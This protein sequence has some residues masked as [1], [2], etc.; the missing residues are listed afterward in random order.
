[1][2]GKAKSKPKP[3][4]KTEKVKADRKD[5]LL[6]NLPLGV[7]EDVLQDLEEEEEDLDIEPEDMETE[8][9][10]EEEDLDI[11]DNK[12]IQAIIREKPTQAG[13]VSDD[14]VRLYLREIGRVKLLDADSEFRLA[15]ILEAARLVKNVVQTKRPGRKA[16]SKEKGIYL[17]VIRIL[18][19]CKHIQVDASELNIPLPDQ[20]LML[21]EAQ[22]LKHT[23]Q[24]D[25]PSY[26]RS[27]LDKEIWSQQE[28][29]V[30]LVSTIYYIFLGYYVLPEEMGSWL[31][32][33]LEKKGSLPNRYTLSSKLPKPKILKK[34]IEII[35]ERARDAGQVIIRSNLRLV[36][37][38]AKRYMGRGINFLD[39][40][41]EGNLGLLRAVN[42][43]DPR[44]GFKF[45][46][47]A[48]WWIRQSINRS[49]AEQ[50]RTIRLPVHLFESITR[51]MRVQRDLV[52]ELGA[53]PATTN[54]PW[55]WVIW[56]MKMWQPSNIRFRKK[57]HWTRPYR[58]AGQMPLI[59]WSESCARLK[60]RSHWKDR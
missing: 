36:V 57:Y 37:S 18:A 10:E 55:L 27:Y 59:R 20:S 1:M 56:L 38:V 53:T 7:G 48:T 47:Y 16:S 22:M 12:L 31:L 41:Q 33:H 4:T 50:A 25:Y 39:L 3:K 49:I 34:E 24:S 43:F 11:D 44:K 6:K 8:E 13:E 32:S 35:E 23:W 58:R 45:S 60:S 51:I 14:P 21:A 54:L 2:A 29:R 17:G 42:K 30:N 26:L 15:T 52:Q 19:A 5:D 40:I 28:V 9:I 46:T